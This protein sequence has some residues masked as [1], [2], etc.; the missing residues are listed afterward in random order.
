[1]LFGKKGVLMESLENMKATNIENKSQNNRDSISHSFEQDM[2]IGY[3]SG[4]SELKF[5]QLKHKF[6]EMIMKSINELARGP[7]NPIS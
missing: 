2:E 3:E 4:P 5:P 7:I 1:M 6:Q